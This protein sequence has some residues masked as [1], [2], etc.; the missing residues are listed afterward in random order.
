MRGQDIHAGRLSGNSASQYQKCN[1]TNHHPVEAWKLESLNPCQ[2]A[3][4]FTPTGCIP[5]DLALG[6][7]YT[8]IRALFTSADGQHTLC[9]PAETFVAHLRTYISIHRRVA[10]CKIS[11]NYAS[12]RD[13]LSVRRSQRCL[14]LSL[15]GRRRL[16]CCKPG[17]HG[18]L[19]IQASIAS[20]SSRLISRQLD[21][22]TL[23]PATTVEHE[24]RDIREKHRGLRDAG[25]EPDE[26]EYVFLVIPVGG[27]TC[28]EIMRYGRGARIA[29]RTGDSGTVGTAH[30][31]RT[32]DRGKRKSTGLSPQRAEARGAAG[33]QPARRGSTRM[34]RQ[35]RVAGGGCTTASLH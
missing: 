26:I 24:D 4:D 15:S 19:L 28:K 6:G 11:G 30:E 10:T 27:C 1:L 34:P 7:Y 32:A 8:T 17:Q 35:P 3:A 2:C 23:A 18:Q 5:F 22:T 16:R 20:H 25:A 9:P 29:W 21:R 14:P 12:N 13:D 31:R 33:W